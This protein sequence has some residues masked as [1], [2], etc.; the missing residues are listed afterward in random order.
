MPGHHIC[1]L[2]PVVIRPLPVVCLLSR[3]PWSRKN[4]VDM[5]VLAA[6]SVGI[7]VVVAPCRQA[8]CETPLYVG[9][10]GR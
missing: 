6:V 7:C 4:G 5:V 2:A 10:F 3:C 9:S 1:L 8:Q